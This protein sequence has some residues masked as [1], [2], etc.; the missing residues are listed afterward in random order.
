VIRSKDHMAR[1]K[2]L[3]GWLKQ[4]KGK[5]TERKVS[6][7]RKKREKLVAQLVAWR[8]RGCLWVMSLLLAVIGNSTGKIKTLP[9]RSVIDRSGIPAAFGYSLPHQITH[10]RPI[11]PVVVLVSILW[12]A[13]DPTYSAFRRAHIQGRDVRV[14]GKRSYIVCACITL[15]CRMNV[16]TCIRFYKCYRGFRDCSLL[17]FSHCLVSDLIKTFYI[18]RIILRHPGVVFTFL[19]RLLLNYP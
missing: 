6:G 18:Y 19:Y 9:T 14:Q 2:A 3:G 4:S 10:L 13:W 11:L 17:L 12:T 15:S 16:L 5:E 1:T 7:S 8:V